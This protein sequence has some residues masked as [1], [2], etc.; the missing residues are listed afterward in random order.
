MSASRLT[1]SHLPNNT[2][3]PPLIPP[4]SLPPVLP[5][6]L[7][8]DQ[9]INQPISATIYE[10][11]NLAHHSIVTNLRPHTN[12]NF[13]P[14]LSA[15]HPILTSH[16][17]VPPLRGGGSHPKEHAPT[18]PAH[19]RLTSRLRQTDASRRCA[20]LR[21]GGEG[22]DLSPPLHH[23]FHHLLPPLL[24]PERGTPPGDDCHSERAC[25]EKTA[26]PSH[27]R[28]ISFSTRHLALESTFRTLTIAHLPHTCSLR[29]CCIPN[30]HDTSRPSPAVRTHPNPPRPLLP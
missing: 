20:S 29:T 17:A 10:S 7:N 22:Q 28:R 3:P 11:I 21:G 23:P 30:S 4:P 16:G 14:S 2:Y 9:S 19:S 12:Q 1:V 25:G 27:W 13:R 8:H 18:R 15:L 6:Y 24:S 5:S 26:C